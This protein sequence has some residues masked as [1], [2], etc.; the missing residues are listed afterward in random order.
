MEIRNL[1]PTPTFLKNVKKKVVETENV[2]IVV[3]RRHS[4]SFTRPKNVENLLSTN[5]FFLKE[6]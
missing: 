2:P 1:I 4:L 3:R 6:R 5:V